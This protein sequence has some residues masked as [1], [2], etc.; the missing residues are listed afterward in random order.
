LLPIWLSIYFITGA[1][2]NGADEI[3]GRPMSEEGST[4]APP[5]CPDTSDSDWNEEDVA[6]IEAMENGKYCRNLPFK[7]YIIT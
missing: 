3:G 4:T 1:Q 7:Y 5:D 6:Q 2:Q